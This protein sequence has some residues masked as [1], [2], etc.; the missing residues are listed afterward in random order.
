MVDGSGALPVSV[1]LAIV[2][3]GPQSLTLVTHLLQKKR[4]ME[5]RF[6]V[7]DPAGNW[8]R[9]WQ[10]QFAAYGIPHLRSPAVHHPDPNPHALRAFA[11]SRSQEL[12]PPYDLPGTQLFEDFC[13]DVIERWNLQRRVIPALVQHI[14]LFDQKGRQ[15]FRLGLADGRELTARRVVLAIAGG[16]PHLPP[17]ARSLPLTYPPDRLRHSHQVDLRGSRFTG[18]RVLIVGS[19]LTS[20]HLALGAIAQ[21]AEVILMARRQ[22]YEKLFDAD[23]GWLGP[24]YLKGFHG[25]PDWENRWQMIQSARNGGSL[26]H[27]ILTQLRR[28]E[29]QGKLS[30]YEQCE[31]QTAAWHEKGW[32]VTCA[33]RGTHGDGHDCIAHLPI[34]RIWLATGGTINVNHWPLLSDVRDRYPL[35]IIKGLPIL[36]HHLR[37]PGCELFIMGGAAALHIGPVARNLFGAKLASDRIV[38]ALIK[39][40]PG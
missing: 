15:R 28:L 21:G 6:V 27:A 14:E 24:K 2:G 13:Q 35:P 31:V 22:F 37:W 11:A 34:D 36:D 1:D 33:Q 38:Q 19:G 25:E 7:L 40:S 23:P 10:E 4:S 32:N 29:R 8:L 30:F 18:E 9:Q 12:F 16:D 17:W 20:G 3:A 26:T 39:D 5:S